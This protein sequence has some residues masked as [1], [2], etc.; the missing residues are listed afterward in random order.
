MPWDKE[1]KIPLIEY[2]D[3]RY[4]QYKNIKTRG[5][6]WFKFYNGFL[7]NGIYP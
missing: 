3:L 6:D 5:G 2:W 7:E 4:D 1:A